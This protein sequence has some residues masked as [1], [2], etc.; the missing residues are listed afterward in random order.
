MRKIHRSS[1]PDIL[2]QNASKWNSQWTDLKAKNPS[3][4]F[5]WYRVDGKSARDWILPD[6]AAMTQGHFA[7]VLRLN[8]SPL[9]TSVPRA[10]AAF[11]TWRILGKI[12]FFVAVD[13]KTKNANN[14]MNYYSTQMPMIIHF[15]ATSYSISPSVRFPRTLDQ[16][17]KTNQKLER[18][19]RFMV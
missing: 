11:Y 14:G 19:F 18:Q 12:C 6:L 8:P 1:E 7:T 4:Q 9:N 10:I 3:A 13:A 5:N 17:L 15:H 16:V 2:V